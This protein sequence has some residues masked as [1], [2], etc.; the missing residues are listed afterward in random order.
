MHTCTVTTSMVFDS[1]GYTSAVLVIV[2]YLT[3][4]RNQ[5]CAL[6]Q[7]FTNVEGLESHR[8]FSSFQLNLTACFC[9]LSMVC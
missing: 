3:A 8:A 1:V 6:L 7:N 9:L 2:T 4:R 5:H